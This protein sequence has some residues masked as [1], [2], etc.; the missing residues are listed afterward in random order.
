VIGLRPEWLISFARIRT[1]LLTIVIFAL[2]ATSAPTED[3]LIVPGARIGKW[4]LQMTID[5]LLRVNGPATIERLAAG[6]EQ[7][8]AARRDSWLYGWAS[9]ALGAE[10]FDT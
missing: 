6:E 9:A 8:L 5:D 10:T 4:T 3:Y 2:P 7:N 1:F